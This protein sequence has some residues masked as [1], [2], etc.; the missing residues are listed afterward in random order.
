MGLPRSNLVKKPAIPAPASAPVAPVRTANPFEAASTIP[1]GLSPF[2]PPAVP[3]AENPFRTQVDSVEVDSVEVDLDQ[4]SR[5]A[6]LPPIAVA[7]PPPANPMSAMNT[8]SM[9]IEPSKAALLERAARLGPVRMTWESI[10]LPSDPVL[11]E[12]SEPRVIERRARFRKI[13]TVALGGCLALCVAAIGA[14]LLSG[15]SNDSASTTPIARTAPAT[16]V[17]PVEKLDIAKHGRARHP[18]AAFAPSKLK[19]R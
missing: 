14:S 9:M 17:V 6:P 11:I 5:D 1:Q 2:A 4:T 3:D 13:V 18:T 7:P 10:V 8:G 15:S 19:R 12:K 16:A